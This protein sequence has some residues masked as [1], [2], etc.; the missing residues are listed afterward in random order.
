M[1]RD[2]QRIH[3]RR[4]WTEGEE[5]RLIDADEFL[6]DE[7]DAFR[8]TLPKVKD[9]IDKVINLG[10]HLKIE[11]LI[12]DCPTADAVPVVHACYIKNKNKFD[13]FECS[14]CHV[15]CHVESVCTK[16]NKYCPCCGA[17]MD[18]VEQ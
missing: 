2:W 7:N 10:T 3:S 11:K 12:N 1:S 8:N 17:R 5:M 4:A 16:F 13:D 15:H 18:E 6:N 9:G 14:N